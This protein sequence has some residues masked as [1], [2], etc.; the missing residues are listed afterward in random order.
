MLQK[1]LL[2]EIHHNYILMYHL[3][4]GVNINYSLTSFA[5]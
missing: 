1:Q 4:L 2:F 5:T 3:A